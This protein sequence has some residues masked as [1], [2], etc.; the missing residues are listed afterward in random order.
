[1][2]RS[3]GRLLAVLLAALTLLASG[4]GEKQERRTSA[5]K[6]SGTGAIRYLRNALRRI[7][8]SHS[9]RIYGQG[10]SQIEAILHDRIA[11]MV[12]PSFAPYA[13][14]RVSCA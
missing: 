1:M 2:K 14:G 10:E 4:C 8:V 9:R 11:A 12:N 13:S 5:A 7:I 3:T 6:C